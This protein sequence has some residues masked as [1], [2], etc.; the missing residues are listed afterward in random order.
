MIALT[1]LKN[2]LALVVSSLIIISPFANTLSSSHEDNV[3]MCPCEFPPQPPPPP[4]PPPSSSNN[5][6]DMTQ[7]FPLGSCKMPKLPSIPY[8]LVNPHMLNHEQLKSLCFTVELTP[9]WHDICSEANKLEECM[10]MLVNLNKIVF[11]FNTTSKECG[12]DEHIKMSPNKLFVWKVPPSSTSAGSYTMDDNIHKKTRK[13]ALML[14]KWSGVFRGSSVTSV[15]IDVASSG[16]FKQLGDETLKGYTLCLTYNP[17]ILD[18]TACITNTFNNQIKYSF[19]DAHK[20][21]CTTGTVIHT[22]T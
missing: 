8:M 20:G 2:L 14:Y 17:S 1:S 6:A 12:Y 5:D 10:N 7:A 19:F 3:C 21:L 18:L 11:W 15:Q 9:N 22:F 16:P 4:S 13:G